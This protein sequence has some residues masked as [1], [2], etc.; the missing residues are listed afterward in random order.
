MQYSQNLVHNEYKA[1]TA[2][3]GYYRQ[4]NISVYKNA[5][6]N[7]AAIH[8]CHPNR[9]TIFNTFCPSLLLPSRLVGNTRKA[10]RSS[11]LKTFPY[12]LGTFLTRGSFNNQLNK[13]CR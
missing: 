7:V 10:F 2:G 8:T 3:C 11:N 13:K 12:L 1:E 4:P 6:L 5:A 9:I